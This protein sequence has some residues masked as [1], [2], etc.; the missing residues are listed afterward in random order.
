MTRKGGIAA[1]LALA[2]LLASQPLAAQSAADE[3]EL[4]RRLDIMLMVTALRCRHGADDFQADYNRFAVRHL[5]TLN[6]A[7]RQM[8]AVHAAHYG[9][10]S[11]RRYLDTISTSMAN[12]Y[13]QGH[14]WLDCAA[15]GQVT[16]GLAQSDGRQ[17]LLAAAEELLADGAPIRESLVARYGE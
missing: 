16:R 9:E 1:A 8:Q 6:Q 13:G 2:G 4:L 10:R 11:A 14:P 12:R 5:A 3:A 7:S 17:V 15:L